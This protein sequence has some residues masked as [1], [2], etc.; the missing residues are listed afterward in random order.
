[1]LLIL[2]NQPESKHLLWIVTVLFAKLPWLENSKKPTSNY[3]VFLQIMQE[4]GSSVSVTPYLGSRLPPTFVSFTPQVIA[5][6]ETD[7]SITDIGFNLT[8]RGNSCLINPFF[9]VKIPIDIF[10]MI[11]MNQSRVFQ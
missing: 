11:F 2:L 8:Y 10:C 3:L 1:M 5:F 4:S 7:S 6:F 9:R